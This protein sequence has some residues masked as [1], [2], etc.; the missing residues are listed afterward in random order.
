MV[1]FHFTHLKRKNQP[2]FAKNVIGKCQI[3]KSKGLGP[4]SPL[5]T[6]MDTGHYLWGVQSVKRFV[7]VHLHCMVSN[8]KKISKM[9]AFLLPGKLSTD[10]HDHQ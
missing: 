6:P 3:K 10:T 8:L 7:N 1:K 2:F 9:S 4:P 5:P